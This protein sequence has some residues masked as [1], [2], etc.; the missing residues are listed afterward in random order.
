LVKLAGHHDDSVGELAKI[1]QTPTNAPVRF[2]RLRS[3]R[4]FLPPRHH[5]PSVTGVLVRRRRAAT[6][7]WEIERVN[8]P[9]EPEQVEA[10]EHA[11]RAELGLIE[12]EENVLSRNRGKLPAMP[13]VRL[14][15]AGQIE[16]HHDT[17]E[18]RWAMSVRARTQ[19]A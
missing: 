12:E 19:C 15:V 11:I 7:E 10:V 9:K 1:T 16:S 2:R 5:D 3:G 14:A 13:P 17:S 8:P 4:G 18:R 6:G